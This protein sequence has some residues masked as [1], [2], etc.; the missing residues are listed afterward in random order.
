ME[1]KNLNSFFSPESTDM[2]HQSIDELLI[3]NALN[4]L[5]SSSMEL[6]EGERIIKEWKNID[7]S[8]IPIFYD[9]GVEIF[10]EGYSDKEWAMHK[11]S[12]WNFPPSGDTRSLETYQKRNPDLDINK[13]ITDL[14]PSFKKGAHGSALDTMSMHRKLKEFIT[15]PNHKYGLESLIQTFRDNAP[16]EKLVK[17]SDDTYELSDSQLESLYN[18]TSQEYDTYIEMMSAM[19]KLKQSQYQ[20]GE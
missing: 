15:D 8:Q 13:I 20:W 1:P 17:N 16:R 12:L 18:F 4:K 2:S 5:D 11:A 19:A 9:D 6:T 10:G 7:Y 3:L 14:A